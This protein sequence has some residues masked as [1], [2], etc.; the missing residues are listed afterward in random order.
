MAED[1]EWE[2]KSCPIGPIN[3]VLKKIDDKPTLEFVEIEDID[4][5]SID[6]GDMIDPG[7][8]FLHLRLYAAH[9]PTGKETA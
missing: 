7:N 3:I 8:G 5:N 4:G 2:E 9:K 6:I 1:I